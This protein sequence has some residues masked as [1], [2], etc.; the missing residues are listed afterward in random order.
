MDTLKFTLDT[1]CR[2]AIDESGAEAPSLRVLADAHTSGV[3]DVCLVAISASERQQWGGHLEI[4]SE[5][6]DSMASL[7]LGHLPLLLPMMYWDVTYGDECLWA[8]EQMAALEKELHTVLFP[9]IPQLWQAYCDARRIAPDLP[10][11]DRAWKNAKCDVLALWT[12]I[13]HERQV[14]VTTDQNFHKMSTKPKLI[15]LGA[16]LIE[17]P[18]SAAA[19]LLADKSVI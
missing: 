17:T 8:D 4:F 5:F 12:H 10:T 18:A 13:L 15:A 1:N 14:F 6:R 3:A 7:N 9:T 2:I 16:G 11:P 19:L